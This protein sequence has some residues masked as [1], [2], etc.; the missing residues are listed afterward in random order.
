MASYAKGRD[1]GA[2]SA[3]TA[4]E[5]VMTMIVVLGRAD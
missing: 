4:R 5:W 3:R 1:A 2:L